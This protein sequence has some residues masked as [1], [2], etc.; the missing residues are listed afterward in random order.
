MIGGVND[1][2]RRLAGFAARQRQVFT[3]RQALEAGLS[4]SDFQR[5]RASGLF[6]PYGPHTLHFAGVN[7]DWRGRLLAGIL[8]LG[9]EALISGRSAAALHDLDGFDEGP[10]DF[11]V[12]RQMRGRRAVGV[13]RSTP[14]I[15]PLDRCVIDGLPV[16]SGTFTVVELIGRVEQRELGNAFDS[17]CR[18]G[19]TAEPVG[20]RRITEL[21]RRGR[22]SLAGFEQLLAAGRVE[23]WLERR[24][25][26][27]LRGS[28]LPAPSQQVVHR[29][30]GRHVARVD[31]DFAPLPVIVEVGGSRG[32]LSRDERRRQEHR[33][34]RRGRQRMLRYALDPLPTSTRPFGRQSS[35]AAMPATS[36][37]TGGNV[38]STS[39]SWP[40]TISSS[41]SASSRR[42]WKPSSMA[43]TSNTIGNGRPSLRFS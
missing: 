3:R 42:R 37:L 29:A 14:V 18:K 43:P 9:P 36:S 8:D 12:P 15:G 35:R 39:G 28:G 23:S 26:R 6:V 32:Y 1:A 22:R 34:L 13:V 30:D 7:L 40:G 27:L 21:G 16:T 17:A 41:P 11:L 25:L 24:F 33:D 10:L 2:D 38:C 19:I 4:P 31:F 20:R 5:R